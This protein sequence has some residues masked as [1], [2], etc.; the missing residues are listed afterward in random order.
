MF[1]VWIALICGVATSVAAQEFQLHE[2]VAGLAQPVDIASAR[3]GSGRLFVIEQAGRVRVIVGTNLQATAFLDITGQTLFS[4]EQGLLGLAFHPGYRTNGHFFVY[5]TNANGSSNVVW[6]YTATPPSTNVVNPA[7]GA[8]II[9]IAHPVE[10]NHNGGGIQFG[11]DGYLYFAPGDGGG[12]CDPNNHSQDLGTL[13]GKMA[14]IDVDS[15][16]PYAVPPDNPFVG[17]AGARPEIWATGLRNPFRFSFDRETGDLFIAD[18]GQDAQEE[19]NFQAAGSPGGQ[20]YG[21]KCME[22]V[23]SNTCATACAT[24]AMR[25]PIITYDH[26][27]PGPCWSITGGYRYRGSRIPPLAGRYFFADYC[28]SRIWAASEAAGVWTVGTPLDFADFGISTF[29]EDECGELYAAHR[30]NGRIYQIVAKDSDGDGLP[31][32][33]EQLYP[34]EPGDDLDG[35]G[36]T[37]RQEF[38]AG[39]NP[40]DALSA[41]RITAITASNLTFTTSAGRQYTVEAR[42]DIASGQWQPHTNI[43]C[44]AAGETTVSIETASFYRVRLQR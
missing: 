16:V 21:W 6:R 19:V 24:A 29:G 41:L 38:L 18:V 33:F 37:H 34:G 4:G 22:G 3:D 42:P 36:F 11:P 12:A 32:W 5:F 1:R 28:S 43:A 8:E 35:D 15:A 23:L 2:I 9:R 13:L 44:A 17:A 7:S 39:T 25:R 30:G 31:D 20:N 27:P 10:A 14:R 40:L 26:V